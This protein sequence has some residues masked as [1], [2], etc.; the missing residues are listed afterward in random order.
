MQA[1]ANHLGQAVG[2]LWRRDVVDLG[3]Q[4][5]SCLAQLQVGVIPCVKFEGHGE[6]LGS[7]PKTHASAGHCVLRERENQ[8]C[9]A[10]I[11]LMLQ[12]I[13]EYQA[14]RCDMSY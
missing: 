3:F 1:G 4:D 5:G 8:L 10:L 6:A 14:T 2:L 12:H 11:E 13:L 9:N 7:R